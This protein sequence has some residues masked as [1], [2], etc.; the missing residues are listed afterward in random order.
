MPV[1][2]PL[3]VIL[4]VPVSDQTPISVPVSVPELAK[5]PP[6]GRVFPTFGVVMAAFLD[7]RAIAHD[8]C[9]TNPSAAWTGSDV[10]AARAAAPIGR[11]GVGWDIP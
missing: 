9:S 5:V 10:S 7:S 1:I 6:F 2:V 4:A 3:L 11:P 8:R